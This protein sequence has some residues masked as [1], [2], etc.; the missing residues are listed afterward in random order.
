MRIHE[1]NLVAFGPFTDKVLVFDDAK[2]HIVYGPNEAGK[3]SALRGLKALLYGIEER[4]L[5][6]F[7]HTNDKLRIY[8]YLRKANGNELKLVRR[9]GRKNT[10]L[11]LDGEE[12]S[13]GVLV[14]FL[15]GVTSEIFGMLFGIDHRALVQG[16]QE[17][18]E[19]KGEVGQA[20]FSAAIGS[21]ALHTVL[22]RL[23]EEA[24]ALFRPRGSTQKINSALK[25]YAEISKEVRVR[26]LSSSEWDKH[27]RELEQTKKELEK[28]QSELESDRSEVNRLRRIQRV[29]PK[30]AKRRELLQKFELLKDVVVLPDDFTGRRQKAMNKL[31]TAQVI[32]GKATPRLEGLQ[33]RLGGLSIN[34]GLLDQAENIE[35]LH[36]RLGGHRKALQD[37]PH[38]EAEAQQLLT[39]AES[40]LKET[41]PDLKLKDIDKLRPVLARRQAIAELASKNARLNASLEQLESSLRETEMRLRIARKEHNEIPASGSTDSLHRAIAAARKQG[42]LDALVKSTQGHLT[43]LQTECAAGLSRLTLWDGE[44]EDLAGLG[45]PNRESINRF[46][47]VFDEINK[48]FQRYEEKR[49]ETI[50]SLQGISQRLDKIERIGEVPTETALT[51]VRSE[52]DQV[53]QLLR[54]QWVEGED[55]SAEAVCLQSEGALPDAFENRLVS[56]DEVSDRLRREADRVHALANLQSKQE[57]GQRQV[58]KIDEQLGAVSAKK[59]QLVTDWQEL[60][61]PCQI[62]PR[63]PR[64]MRAW[65]DNFEKLRDRVEQLNLLRQK[66]NELQQIRKTHIQLLNEQLAKLGR[67]G[68]T[69]EGLETVLLECEAFAKELDDAK[70][71]RDSL[72]REVKDREETADSLSEE[73]QLATEKLEAWKMQWSEMMQAIGLQSETLPS[74][75][76]NFIEK[77]RVLFSKQREAE[78]LRIRINA[79]EKDAASFCS[80]VEAMVAAIAPEISDLPADD[81]VMRLNSL[82][83]ENRSRQTKRQQIEEQIEQV[84]QEIEDSKASIRAMTDQLD[85]LCVEAICDNHNQLEEAERMSADH[86]RIKDS[87]NTVEQ[88]VLETGEGV[89]I[90]ELEAEVEG[91]EPDM[92]PGRIKELSNKINDELE[93]RRTKLAET[94]G[95]EERELEFMDGSDHVAILAEQS[96]AIL[97]NIRSEAERY[98]QVKLARKILFDQIERYRKENQGPLVKRASEHFSKL[99]LG[100]FEGL[101]TDFNDKDEPVLAG[102]RSTGKQVYVEGMSTGTRDQLYLALRLASLEK[103]LESSEPMPFIVDD[104]LIDFDDYRSQVALSSLAELAGKTQV[105]LFTHH[106]QVVEQSKLLNGPVQVHKL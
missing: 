39:D 18:L 19:Q 34:Q 100:S 40:I 78:K 60:W 83:S 97:A 46:E 33:V 80:Q 68:L 48:R 37:R 65:L 23:D 62:V 79:I 27:R 15:H 28:I 32:A 99:T 4:T 41:H 24:D 6:N 44:L 101:I 81:A 58:E 55:V 91:I 14:P 64:E 3:S 86:L 61:S 7:L 31:E 9:K 35:D 103:Y 85:T 74:A 105:I 95:R 38:L 104:I 54:R 106:S 47:K 30:L 73:H 93:P 42:E 75:V 76:D 57:G 98:I 10:L 29:L 8:G 59:D 102:A 90:A 22:V 71:K 1:L 20:L 26:S 94:K 17:I 70:Q 12:L 67:T 96:H 88:E 16:G 21:Q 13:D 87:I 66:V 45:I 92:L 2:L 50:N 11:T 63:S 25:S 82:L 49:E 52:R 56:A 36:A 43:S 72:S 53:W 5:D 51:N 89:A 84:K 69:S 77:V